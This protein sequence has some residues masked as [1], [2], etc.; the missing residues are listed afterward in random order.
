M[1]ALS[2]REMLALQVS[3]R[4]MSAL[5]I[6]GSSFILFTF[7]RWQYFRKPINRLV[8]Y[9]SF[10]NILTNVATLIATSAIP[11]GPTSRP[12]GLCEFQGI[13]IQWFM[14]ADSLWV[15]CM[16]LNVMLVF[17]WNYGAD[18]LPHL[19]KWYALFSYGLPSI[20]AII[21]IFMDH[22][23][24]QRIIGAA[25]IWCW[26][27]KDVEWMR[28][29]F[30]YGPVWVVISFTLAIY[31]ITGRRIF[32]QRSQL[33]SFS[34]STPVDPVPVIANPFTVA[35]LNN[36]EK[37][38]DIRVVTET[39]GSE[40]TTVSPTYENESRT[41]FSST[42]NLSVAPPIAPNASRLS[43]INWSSGT[44]T[45]GAAQQQQKD[46][47][48][49]GYQVTVTAQP[50]IPDIESAPARPFSVS[51][52]TNVRRNDAMEGNSNAWGY[53]K[54]AF[55]MF[56]ALFIV[57]VPSTINRMQQFAYK[58]HPIFGLNLASALVLPLQGFWNAMVYISCSWSDCRR[59][60]DEVLGSLG[61]AGN[62]PLRRP[63]EISEH[64]LTHTDYESDAEIPLG[65]MLQQGARK[66]HSRGSSTVTMK[67]PTL[68][69]IQH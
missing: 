19:E 63:R 6:I 38:T 15:F 1:G 34:R 35:N 67:T 30:F 65:E 50:N 55:L 43:P 39:I 69:Q 42:R 52:R 62:P 37:K 36:I 22:L 49:R 8:F 46:D 32:K 29:A 51:Q 33:R 26:V 13:I 61:F 57:W 54:V 45:T 18:E 24:N 23:G 48:A 9:A 66:L 44:R 4:T 11:Q 56:A 27:D 41:S 17:F 59:A 40:T 25:T 20:P 5:S 14:M 53:F 58:G 3:E 21:Y 64:T 16:A 28:I 31:A 68:A 12:S 2:A 60:W 10:G 7:L 47:P